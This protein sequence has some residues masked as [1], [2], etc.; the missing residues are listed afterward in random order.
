MDGLQRISGATSTITLGDTALRCSPLTL[1]GHGEIES[2]LHSLRA[3]EAI[4][5]AARL[6]GVPVDHADIILRKAA[7]HAEANRMIG[8]AEIQ[9][10]QS[11]FDGACFLLWLL[12]RE[13]H[14][15][16]ATHEDLSDIAASVEW[17]EFQAK[18]D[19]ASCVSDAKR[20]RWPRSN[21]GAKA[22]SEKMAWAKLYRDLAREYQW[23]P[24]Q[25]DELT[26]YQAAM[27]LGH[28]VP[29]DGDVI[30]MKPHERAAYFGN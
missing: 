24:A 16:Y 6:D 13:H 12:A 21:K 5:A 28:L 20:I 2:R 23:T 9:E 7:A 25:V 15:E 3:T 10:Y 11:T 17:P 29:E 27:Y 30:A 19:A 4:E 8:L 14:P 1:G 18:L 22:E 26:F